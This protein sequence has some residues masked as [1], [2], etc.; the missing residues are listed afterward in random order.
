MRIYFNNFINYQQNT[1]FKSKNEISITAKKLTKAQI[2]KQQRNETILK[3]LSEGFTKTEIAKKL[4]IT[5]ETINNFLKGKLIPSYAEQAMPRVVER[6]Q[7]GE[8]LELIMQEEKLSRNIV[9][10]IAAKSGLSVLTN[11][12]KN[13]QER[14]RLIEEMLLQGISA[15]SIA[16]ELNITI[17][18]VREIAKRTKSHQIYKEERFLN[19]VKKINS[20]V[21]MEQILKEEN[22]SAYVYKRIEKEAIKKN[23]IIDKK[24][25]QID[26]VI[27]LIKD[28]KT[29]EEIIQKEH[30]SKNSILRIASSADI[31][32]LSEAGKKREK[33]NKQILDMLLKGFTRSQIVE[34]LDVEISMVNKIAEENKVFQKLIEQ[35]SE[36]IINK[37]KQ[38]VPFAKIASDEG[39]N[40]ATVSR[41]VKKYGIK[42]INT[43][44]YT[45]KQLERND[46]IIADIKKGISISEIAK[47]FNVSYVTVL[48]IK[49]ELGLTRKYNYLPTPQEF[50]FA[51]IKKQSKNITKLRETYRKFK[52]GER[53]PE[54]L[55]ELERTIIELK[56]K[57]QEFKSRLKKD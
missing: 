24:K 39:I 50:K 28:G 44:E 16:K 10:S 43:P 11:F 21:P 25:E 54:I 34:A 51:E 12:Q 46:L 8:P 37:I 3:M 45:K 31:K 23:L 9:T 17:T 36:R 38:G 18:K 29:I 13:K 1:N 57:I 47:K 53:T 30:L 52:L 35:R 20:N 22:I 48:K 32:V 42:M 55:D 6:I 15:T 27:N 5:V 4:Y 7:R 49:K 14:D 40:E 2:R 33:R 19:I 26:R 41:T 56:E